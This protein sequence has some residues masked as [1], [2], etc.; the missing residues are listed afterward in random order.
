MFLA[1]L[2]LFCC[3]I[4]LTMNVAQIDKVTVKAILNKSHDI[5]IKLNST[6]IKAV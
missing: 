5:N 1:N 3:F 4:G 2:K 6:Q